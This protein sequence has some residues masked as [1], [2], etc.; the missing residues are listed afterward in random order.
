[1]GKGKK[2]ARSGPP[3]STNHPSN[4][5]SD[6]PPDFAVL[7]SLYPSF[8]P[9]VF[10]SGARPRIDWT[11]YNATRE[12]TRIL[13]LHDH[14]LN[15]WI[16]DGQLCPTVPNRSNYIH[17]INDL[18]SSEII[19][20]CSG[21]KVKGFDI[22]TGA[23]CIYPLLGASLF[24][25]IFVASDVTAVALEWAAKN[26]QSNPH[27][28]DLIEIR[29]SK[30]L[31]DHSSE[32]HV[33]EVVDR[34]S[35]KHSSQTIP[36]EETTTLHSDSLDDV[37]KSYMGPPILLGVVKENETFDFCMSNPPFFE[38]FGEAGLNPKTSC[39]GTPEEMVCNGGEQAFV[40]R[41]IQDSIILRQR[42]RWYTSM[43]GKKANLKLLI[44]K[45]WEVGV[46]VVKTTEFVQ[47][48]TSRWGLAW[49][50]IP[51]ARKIISPPVAKKSISS[52]MLEGITRQYSAADVLQSVE[53]F[54]K[55][56]GA[57]CKLNS[58][59][60][61][62]D[63]VASSDQCNI[64]SKN[65]IRDVETVRSHGYEKQSLDSSS[66]Q[67]PEDNLSFRILVFQQMPGTLL[68]KGSL[69]QKDSPLSGLF[70]VVFCSLEESMKSKFCR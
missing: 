13:L 54:F 16:P 38:T 18:L 40:T 25:W 51:T 7:A 53:E 37:N 60:F 32:S 43:L 64:I 10:F 20:S 55:S 50:F 24:G 56:C 6:N 52:F 9:F 57:S 17:W 36:A 69:Q 44:S 61:S 11:D 67:V 14:S 22:G 41:I 12:L 46:T 3:G 31:P 1:M 63:I 47:G 39:G 23:N 66:L 15:W 34:E 65:G 58:S 8:K 26:V 27:I 5:Y 49:S 4:R 30:P 48:Q 70:S 62:V 28:S 59:T 29:D 35:Q 2:R 45:L 68:I 33:P 21:S 42:F 19:P